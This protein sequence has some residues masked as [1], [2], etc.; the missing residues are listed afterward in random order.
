MLLTFLILS[1][2]PGIFNDFAF[3]KGSDLLDE[4]NE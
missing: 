4:E 3:F 2:I 1:A